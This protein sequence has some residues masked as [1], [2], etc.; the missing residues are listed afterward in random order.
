M[1][2][3]YEILCKF[4]PV[5]DRAFGISQDGKWCLEQLGILARPLQ[6]FA[7]D[8]QNLH[9]C[10]D[11]LIIQ[12]PQLGDMRSALQSLVLSHEEQDNFFAAIIGKFDLT[13][14]IG[15][16]CEIWDRRSDL[17]FLISHRYLLEP[18]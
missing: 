16:E 3:P 4:K 18:P 17:Q 13:A 10:L 1:L 15:W 7:D 5:I 12:A 2:N 6:R 14:R 9:S 11:K 8:H